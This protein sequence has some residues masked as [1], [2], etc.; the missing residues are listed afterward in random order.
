MPWSDQQMKVARAVEHGWEPTGSAKGFTRKFAKQVIRE[1]VKRKNKHRGKSL[2]D[3][4]RESY[5]GR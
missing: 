1:G 2:G 5:G 3:M 4:M